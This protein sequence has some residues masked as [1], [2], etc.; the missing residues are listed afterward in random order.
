MDQT[1]CS[2]PLPIDGTV[3]VSD[4]SFGIFERWILRLGY[5]TARLEEPDEFRGSVLVFLRP[6]LPV[7]AQFRDRV[8]EYVDKGGKVLVVEAPNEKK[9]PGGLTRITS[10]AVGRPDTPRRSPGKGWPP[11]PARRQTSCWR[12]SAFRSIQD[13][14]SGVLTSSKGWPAVP[15]TDAYAVRGSGASARPF[16]WVNDKPVAVTLPWGTSGGSVT[17]VGFGWRFKDAQMGGTDF[18]EPDKLKPDE[19]R[20]LKDVYQWH[21]GLFPAIVSGSL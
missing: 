8:A 9:R 6:D 13:E 17:V 21:F 19:A 5:F 1:V 15:V 18:V 14:A 4:D 12:G 10:S 2:M 7:S 11:R 20:K 16:A 3:N